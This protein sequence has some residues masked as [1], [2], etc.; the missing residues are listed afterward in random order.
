MATNIQ[1]QNAIASKNSKYK[2]RNSYLNSAKHINDLY[3]N[4]GYDY[5]GKILKKMTS[6]ELW[7]NP[8]QPP[9]FMQLEAILTFL[10]EQVKSI[11]KTFSISHSKDSLNLN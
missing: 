7:A 6:P 5:R 3:I 11:K 10:I 9:M 1:K 4:L 2:V 8:I